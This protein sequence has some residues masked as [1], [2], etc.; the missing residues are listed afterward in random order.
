[1]TLIEVFGNLFN[2]SEAGGLSHCASDLAKAL[3]WHFIVDDQ[4]HIKNDKSQQEGLPGP[5][6]FAAENWNP[7]LTDQ[8]IHMHTRM[9]REAARLIGYGV[10][11][12]R[13]SLFTRDQ[14]SWR[15]FL[16]C[17]SRC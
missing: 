8:E 4:T 2:I 14:S 11:V 5:A 12:E 1:V 15:P 10:L 17:F 16:R 13:V 7:G 3:E 6:T 9:S